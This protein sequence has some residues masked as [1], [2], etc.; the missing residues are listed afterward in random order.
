VALNVNSPLSSAGSDPS[1]L[2]TG[3]FAV[4]SRYL[5]HTCGLPPWGGARPPYPAIY[6]ACNNSGGFHLTGTGTTWNN[7]TAEPLEVYVR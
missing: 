2:W 5:W 4:D 1:A 7:T 6:W 3:P